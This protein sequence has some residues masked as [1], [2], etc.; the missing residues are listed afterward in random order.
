MHNSFNFD[1][2]FIL[3]LSFTLTSISRDNIRVQ[4]QLLQN[5]NNVTGWGGRLNFISHYIMNGTHGT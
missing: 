4:L 3:K 2:A 5:S 1:E